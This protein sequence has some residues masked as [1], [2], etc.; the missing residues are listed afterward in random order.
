MTKNNDTTDEV[1]VTHLNAFQDV[2]N[3]SNGGNFGGVR[4]DRVATG[5]ATYSQIIL[6]VRKGV[7]RIMG[8]GFTKEID[9]PVV[10]LSF[11]HSDNV[12]GDAASLSDSR[13]K[14]NQKLSPRTR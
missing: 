11:V 10:P 6:K 13:L 5:Y 12:F 9:R 2:S 14:D 7:L 3:V 1:F 4:V 8:L